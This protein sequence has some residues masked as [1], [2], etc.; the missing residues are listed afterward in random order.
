MAESEELRIMRVIVGHLLR[1]V[2]I[3]DVEAALAKKVKERR[4]SC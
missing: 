2:T 3:A 4:A 1:G